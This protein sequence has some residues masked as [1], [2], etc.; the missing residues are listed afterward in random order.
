MNN[1][2]KILLVEDAP[3][4]GAVLKNYLELSGFDVLL[5]SDGKKGWSTFNTGSFDLCI[6]DVMLPEMDGLTLAKEIRKVNEDIPLIFLTAR[7]Q[8]KDVVIG[9]ESGAD[10]YIT[11][12]FDSELLIHKINALL[13]RKL[14]LTL[15]DKSYSIGS[16]TYDSKFRTLIRKD[17]SRKLS[18]KESKLLQLFCEHINDILPRDKALKMIWK[19]DNYFTKRSMDVYITKLR[20]YLAEDSRIEIVNIHSNGY[21]LKT[22][23]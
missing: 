15:E 11:K 3:N 16:F 10:D 8:K 7:S 4:L 13:R 1:K 20:K 18:P 5:K 12:P 14:T 22:F 21:M 19:N 9:Y 6:L 2:N 23:K 17:E